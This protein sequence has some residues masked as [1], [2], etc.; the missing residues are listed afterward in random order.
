MRNRQSH[1]F[2]FIAS[3]LGCL[4]FAFSSIAI[5][6]QTSVLKLR[7]GDRISGDIISENTNQ[8]TISN[9][10][11]K[12]ITIPLA[13]IQSRE[14]LAPP[15]PA[16]NAPVIAEVA[17]PPAAVVI[18][19]PKPAVKPKAPNDWHGDI[20]V[21]ADLGFSEKNRQL[22]YGLFKITYAPVQ[23]GGP[24]GASRLIDRFQN[25]F[26]Y[27]AAY[28]TT[29][30]KL[31]ANRMAGS[32]KT[33]FNLGSERRIFIYNLIGAGY[34]EIRK[35]D[36]SF[37]AGPGVGYHLVTRSNFVLNVETG[38]NYQEQ[39]FRDHT[40]VER[41]YYRFAEDITFKIS[42][43]LTFDEKFEFFPQTDFSQYRMVFGSNLRYWFLEN[44]SLNLT[45][46]DI[47][48]TTVAP[49]VE[50]NDLQIRSSIGVKF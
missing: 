49:N 23:E 29:D 11:T 44:I 10:W 12:E 38:L 50:R 7:N 6:A 36:H 3:G 25:T 24:G 16:T 46:L 27:N 30:G 32:S 35:I 14:T 15:A 31:S 8:V 2:F 13:E 47:Y 48:N 33:A 40:K 20:Q 9:A 34:D 18:A 1:N 26:E 39:Y 41:F 45:L 5:Q 17:P 4:L 21:G 28:G 42:K 22:Y 37:E 19:P 43:T